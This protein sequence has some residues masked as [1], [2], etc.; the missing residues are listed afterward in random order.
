MQTRKKNLCILVMMLLILIIASACSTAPVK[1]EVI[2]PFLSFPYFPDPLGEDGK[3]IPMLVEQNVVIPLFYWRKIA[4][5][6]IE[7]DK[8]REVY[9]AWRDIYIKK[10]E[11]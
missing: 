11:K 5:Y 10:E 4:E 3:P 2:D 1:T 8:I 6:V 9:E 7:V